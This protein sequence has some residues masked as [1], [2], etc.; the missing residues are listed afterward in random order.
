[1]SLTTSARNQWETLVLTTSEH[2]VL[3][4]AGGASAPDPY[5]EPAAFRRYATDV[6]AQLNDS[7]RERVQALRL[8]I[9]PRPELYIANLPA[10][11]SLPPTPTDGRWVKTTSGH[12]S[13]LLMVAFASEL[14]CPISYADQRSG[15]VFH[16]IYPTRANAAAVSS[17]SHL[18]GLGFH[19]EMFFHPTP[20]D[21]LVLH[22]LRPDPGGAALTGV[23][24]MASVELSLS[25]ADMNV[26][27]APSFALDLARLHGSYTYLG[28]PI[29]EA[30]P[31]PCVPVVGR[32][33]IRFEPALTTPTSGT[34]QRAL[35]SAERVAEREVAFGA[36]GDGAMLLVDNRRAVHS[37]TSFP[38]RYD[39]TDRWLRRMMVAAVD[40][41]PADGIVRFSDLDLMRPWE[42]CGAAFA[43]VPYGRAEVLA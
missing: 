28:R 18:V 43:E 38:A 33:R 15:A 30:D 2:D 37:R 19:S 31:R 16:D 17:Q 42:A 24:D 41:P 5:T 32:D 10:V 39:G 21:F 8:G 13:E 27:S 9:S 35:V 3:A 1:M 12:H 22:C 14:G 23:S 6:W 4:D 40:T 26:L 20:P 7:T 11:P 36:L 34:A 25:R 29:A